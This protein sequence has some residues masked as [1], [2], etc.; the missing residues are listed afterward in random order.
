MCDELCLHTGQ[1]RLGAKTHKLTSAAV[2][3]T[4]TLRKAEKQHVQYDEGEKRCGTVEA[5]ERG[6]RV[7]LKCCD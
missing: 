7:E 3:E 6:R 2:T 4:F 5:T 1:G